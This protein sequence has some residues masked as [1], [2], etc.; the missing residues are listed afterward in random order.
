MRHQIKCPVCGA[1]CWT[2]GWEE[3][4]DIAAGLCDSNL[5]ADACEHI[6]AGGD[7]SI[8]DTEYEAY[9]DGY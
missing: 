7:Y 2:R 6:Q 1:T 8:I 3:P 4:D 5:L 9:D